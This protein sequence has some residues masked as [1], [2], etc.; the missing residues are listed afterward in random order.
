MNTE[1]AGE[2]ISSIFCWNQFPVEVEKFSL[3]ICISD[4][5]ESS[6]VLKYINL[7][8]P[9]K[10]TLY[11]KST[12][13][14]DYKKTL[15]EEKT[16]IVFNLYE[17]DW[18]DSFLLKSY[19]DKG[20][21]ITVGEYENIPKVVLTTSDVIIFDSKTIK[22]YLQERHSYITIED[23]NEDTYIVLDRRRMKFEFKYILKTEVLFYSDM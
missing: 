9:E 16:T 13:L 14:Y 11:K 12:D 1:N 15:E 2:E 21:F 6:R 10:T 19:N 4:E 7:I 23:I 20:Y 8:F 18:V 3:C 5:E 22:K 17:K